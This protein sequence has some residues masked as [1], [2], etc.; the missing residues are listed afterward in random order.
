MAL[1]FI[2][3]L[4]A[5]LAIGRGVS[6][7]SNDQLSADIA[8][9]LDTPYVKVYPKDFKQK[10]QLGAYQPGGLFSSPK[11]YVDEKEILSAFNIKSGTAAKVMTGFVIFHEYM[12]QVLGHVGLPEVGPNSSANQENCEHMAINVKA[13]EDYL[14]GWI[15]VYLALP[16]EIAPPQS[17][18]DE[19]CMI[20]QGFAGWINSGPLWANCQSLLHTTPPQYAP[21]GDTPTPSSP[22]P[23]CPGC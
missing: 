21:P 9:E 22:V 16:K 2:L 15:S 19:L 1:R 13:L 12:H 17:E 14:C 5:L 18:I 20:A 8:D 4:I 11:I 3:L 7:Q 23:N 6:A 10:G